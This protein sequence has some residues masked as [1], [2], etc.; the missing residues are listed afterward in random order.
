MLAEVNF[1]LFIFFLCNSVCKKQVRTVV[2]N[3]WLPTKICLFEPWQYTCLSSFSF[4]RL[5]VVSEKFKD[6]QNGFQWVTSLFQKCLRILNTLSMGRHLLLLSFL[7]WSRFRT[8]AS[9]CRL[10][11]INKWS[12]WWYD[13][14]CWW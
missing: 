4:T 8:S 2:T 9:L 7:A 14:D 10:I 3:V 5:F 12:I 1:Y 13:D 6:I 11:K